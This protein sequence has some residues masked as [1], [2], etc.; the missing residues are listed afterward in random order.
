MTSP[1]RSEVAFSSE[2]FPARRYRLSTDSS[3]LVVLAFATTEISWVDDSL[4]VSFVHGHDHEMTVRWTE[5][6]D[7]GDWV[8]IEGWNPPRMPPIPTDGLWNSFRVRAR[9]RS[10]N[11]EGFVAEK[12]R[13]PGPGF[14][15]SRSSPP[16]EAGLTAFAR[17]AGERDSG[18][19]AGN[20]TPPTIPNQIRAAHSNLTGET[21]H[22]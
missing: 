7:P 11:A 18:I 16:K 14:L 2:T 6:L 1:A 3:S 13:T 12:A 17:E 8:T 21:H 4:R 15:F 9:L 19:G 5:A 20:A 22:D 10:R